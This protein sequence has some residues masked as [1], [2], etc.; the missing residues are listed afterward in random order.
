MYQRTAVV[1]LGVQEQAGQDLPDSLCDINDQVDNLSN[2]NKEGEHQL[3][4]LVEAPSQLWGSHFTETTAHRFLTVLLYAA[5]LVKY[6]VR[7][8][9]NS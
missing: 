2:Q 7:Y 1:G 8:Q 3:I 5:Q 6:A 4:K 9:V